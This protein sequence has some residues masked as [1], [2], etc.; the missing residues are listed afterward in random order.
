MGHILPGTDDTYYD[1][2]KIEFHRGRYSKLDFSKG[3]MLTRAVHKMI[4]IVELERYL[5]E[6]G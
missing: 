4:N 3:E 5:N 6:G 2:T 1:K